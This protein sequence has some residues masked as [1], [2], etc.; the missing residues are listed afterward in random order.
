MAEIQTV[1]LTAVIADLIKQEVVT[2]KSQPLSYIRIIGFQNKRAMW[3]FENLRI[4]AARFVRFSAS[5]TLVF[6]VLSHLLL[7]F[8]ISEFRPF[9]KE[10]QSN[11]TDTG[12]Y[13][14]VSE[15][16]LKRLR[17]CLE[18]GGVN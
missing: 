3:K 10:I 4:F 14:S 11:G 8:T 16:K 7:L 17:Q 1:L 6:Y 13:D 9:Q 5:T 12:N 2:Y 15:E 18:N